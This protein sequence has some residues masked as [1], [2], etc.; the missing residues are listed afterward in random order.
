M[1]PRNIGRAVAVAV[2]AALAGVNP[3]VLVIPDGDDQSPP[4]STSRWVR[5]QTDDVDAARAG[6]IRGRRAERRTI[7]V[8]VDVFRRG[9]SLQAPGAAGYDDVD[10]LAYPVQRA[11][12]TQ[13]INILD[14]VADPA[15]RTPTGRRLVFPEPAVRRRL[16]PIDG[17][18]RRQV[19]STA[20]LLAE[21]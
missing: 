20:I 15:G 3:E 12:S 14:Y 7:L 8:T 16:D 4:E 17:I 21:V 10:G 18:Q 5:V 11:L 6:K 13:G 9:A 1:D 2:Q 19:T